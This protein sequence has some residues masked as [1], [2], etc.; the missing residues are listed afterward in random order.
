MIAKS[1]T[2][3]AYTKLAPGTLIVCATRMPS[4]NQPWLHGIYIGIIEAPGTDALAWNGH[5]SE[6]HYCEVTNSARVSYDFGKVYH[7]SVCELMPVSTEQAALTGRERIQF[8][9]GAVALWEFERHSHKTLEESKDY[10]GHLEDF[11]PPGTQVVCTN[12]LPS[13]CYPWSKAIQI[14]TVEAPESNDEAARYK[15]QNVVRVRYSEDNV[16]HEKIKTLMPVTAELAALGKREVIKYLLGAVAS[17]KY[18]QHLSE[19][20]TNPESA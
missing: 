4:I 18:D 1:T 8:F 2:Q 20:R 10:W 19:S 3:P 14:G 15:I 17:W 6:A 13:P 16:Q 7:D 12:S 11:V 5:N 9:M